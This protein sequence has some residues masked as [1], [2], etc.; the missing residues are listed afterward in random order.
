MAR[1]G[2]GAETTSGSAPPQRLQPVEAE[3]DWRL[4]SGLGCEIA[5]GY[6]I[7]RPMPAADL[8]PWIPEHRARLRALAGAGRA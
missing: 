7:A 3:E 6:L 2:E 8:L 4:L 1:P 5:Q